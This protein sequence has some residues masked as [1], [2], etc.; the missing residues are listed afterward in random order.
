MCQKQ[1]DISQKLAAART[2]EKKASAEIPKEQRPVYH[3]SVP[4]GW[5]NDPNGFSIFQGKY[6]LFFQYYPY[7]TCWGTMHWGHSTTKDF[8]K[9][10]QEPCA[11]APDMEYDKDGCFS[12]T[13][14]E[15]NDQHLLMYT[16]V[17]EERDE[18]GRHNTR[19]TQC[20]AYG[21]GTNYCK[22]EQNPVITSDLLPEG[23]S[24]ID[25]RDP[26]IWREGDEFQAL[27]GSKDAEGNGQLA[28][29]R[30]DDIFHWEFVKMLDYCHGEYGEMWECPDFFELDQNQ[31]LIVSPQFM[32]EDEEFHNGNN[33]MYFI[34]TYE[35]ERQVWMREKPYLVDYG[36]DFYAAQTTMAKDGRRIMIAWL[37]NWDAYMVPDHYKWSGMTTIPRELT[38]RNGRLIQ[39]PVSEL[40]DYYSDK[41]VFK[42]YVI[43]S[44]DGETKIPQ[45][46]G[47]VM[48][49]TVCLNDGDYRMFQ[50]AVAAD[51]TY[52]TTLT[53]DREAGTLTANRLRSGMKKDVIFARSMRVNTY[54]GKIK[55]R[56]LLDINSIEVFVNDGEQA[57]STLI[58]TDPEVRGILWS[59]DGIVKADIE[60]YDILVD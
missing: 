2:Y 31:V 8:I 36:L 32:T 23:S 41:I 11:M 5:M 58:Y 24:K 14:L 51:D 50:I 39:N 13:A 4:T 9:W 15:W 53:Y 29:F 1:E 46:E 48:D 59:T 26:K 16:G 42:D 22:Y 28:L 21:D 43:R 20:I 44:E 40:A 60:K 47:R 54:Q 52:R 17:W 10:E 7:D 38:V 37:Q 3:M 56:I 25:F 49:L 12:G 35:K 18:E 57:M 30:S 19:Q 33:T 6:H 27:V 45:I 34:G 55:M